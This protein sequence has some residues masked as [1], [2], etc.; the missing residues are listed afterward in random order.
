MVHR[1]KQGEHNSVRFESMEIRLV[2]QFSI[3]EEWLELKVRSK[4]FVMGVLNLFTPKDTSVEDLQE[5]L[6]L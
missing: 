1:T 4:F 6:G 2:R 5:W 3:V